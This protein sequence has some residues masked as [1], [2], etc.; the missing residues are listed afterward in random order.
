MESTSIA[1]MTDLNRK[2]GIDA[3]LYAD[4]GTV[5]LLVLSDCL[6]SLYL[7]FCDCRESFVRTC[8]SWV[9][10]LSKTLKILIDLNRR[11]LKMN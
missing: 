10:Y 3:Y 9:D 2:Y 1:I 11:N 8:R 5:L 6:G 4:I 7:L